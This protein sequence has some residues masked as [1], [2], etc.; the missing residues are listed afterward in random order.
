MIIYYKIIGGACVRA[1]V[2]LY[3]TLLHTQ[4]F[5][6]FPIDRLNTHIHYQIGIFGGTMRDVFYQG[7]FTLALSLRLTLRLKEPL[8]SR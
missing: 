6:D 4:S 5:M 2:C 7:V 1:C 3:V 8:I